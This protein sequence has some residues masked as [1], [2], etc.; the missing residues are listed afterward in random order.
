MFVAMARARGGSFSRTKRDGMFEVELRRETGGDDASISILN[1][2]R[3]RESRKGE[4]KLM[5]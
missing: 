5:Y 2:E 3:G 4:T 1:E